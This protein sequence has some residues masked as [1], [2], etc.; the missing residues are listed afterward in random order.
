METDVGKLYILIAKC[1]K[2]HNYADF[3]FA[4]GPWDK[5]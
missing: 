5:Y 1:M 2:T 4:K 3:L